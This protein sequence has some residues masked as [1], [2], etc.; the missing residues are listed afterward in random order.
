M[1]ALD[2]EHLLTEWNYT[3]SQGLTKYREGND[4]YS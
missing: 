1:K 4:E 2:L 3:D